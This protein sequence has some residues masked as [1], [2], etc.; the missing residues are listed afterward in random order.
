MGGWG[1]E[2]KAGSIHLQ[3]SIGLTDEFTHTET[4]K[5]REK[6]EKRK[7]ES[8]AWLVGLSKH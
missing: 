4:E 1:A 2:R 5:G 3:V 6:R 8:R 7:S